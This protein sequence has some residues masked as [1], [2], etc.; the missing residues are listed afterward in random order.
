MVVVAVLVVLDV[1]TSSL[2][3][4]V[5]RILPLDVGVYPQAYAVYGYSRL[6]SQVTESLHMA[7]RETA[8]SI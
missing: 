4:V 5:S 7:Y 2:P 1:N 8:H 6:T 3:P